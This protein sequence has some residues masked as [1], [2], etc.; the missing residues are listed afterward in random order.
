VT[1]FVIERNLPEGLCERETDASEVR[2]LR[3]ESYE[4]H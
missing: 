2:E 1:R 3:P 4:R